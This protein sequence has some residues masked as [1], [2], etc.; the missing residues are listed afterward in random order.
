V[1]STLGD[2]AWL[3]RAAS[4]PHVRSYSPSRDVDEAT[5]LVPRYRGGAAAALL[6]LAPELS[7][8]TRVPAGRA[9][10]EG[11]S[12]APPPATGDAAAAAAAAAP[13]PPAPALPPP[14]VAHLA[15]RADR[16]ARLA[17]LAW[18]WVAARGSAGRVPVDTL[19][20]LV[21]ELRLDRA[22]LR[23]AAAAAGEVIESLERIINVVAAVLCTVFSVG[24]L[25]YDVG[26][27]W[28]GVG[29]R[30][31]GRDNVGRRG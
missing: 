28:L 27:L 21:E 14:N 17:R 7:G 25:G 23:A 16:D 2:S 31:E 1:P 15:E 20:G 13:P 29:G 4:L 30:A 26:Q 11:A 24:I 10:V 22:R 5:S 12:P 6:M 9:S 19:P 18:E 3:S 8:S